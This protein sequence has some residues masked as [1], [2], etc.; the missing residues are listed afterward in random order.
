MHFN[1]Q[2]NIWLSNCVA[3]GGMRCLQGLDENPTVVQYALSYVQLH[4]WY[5]QPEVQNIPGRNWFPSFHINNTN[6]LSSRRRWTYISSYLTSTNISSDTAQY[7]KSSTLALHDYLWSISWFHVLWKGS[8][9]QSNLHYSIFEHWRSA[10][11]SWAEA[12]LLR[13]W[14]IPHSWSYSSPGLAAV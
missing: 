13:L 3:V 4:M 10:I 2:A 9:K 8:F 12:Y 11:L 1:C 14:S 5:L 6:C 7:W